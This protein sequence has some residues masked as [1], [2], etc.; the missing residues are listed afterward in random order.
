MTNT[1]KG[2][3]AA[4]INSGLGLAVA[5]GLPLSTEQVGAL[6]LFLNAGIAL[7]IA[8]TYKN[9]PRRI[10]DPVIPAREDDFA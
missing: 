3:I 7:F 4:F 10:P 5:F 6:T 9:S 2:L 8:L 1:T